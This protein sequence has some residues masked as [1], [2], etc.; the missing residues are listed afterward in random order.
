M[1]SHGG[2]RDTDSAARPLGHCGLRARPPVEPERQ[3]RRRAAR[4]PR[5]TQPGRRQV[6][7]EALDFNLSTELKNDLKQWRT[8]ALGVGI[9]GAVLCAIGF[10]VPALGGP[11]QFYRSY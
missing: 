11:F 7:A 5:A 3:A 1:R 9:A 8:R 6:T 2:L 4:G 10:L